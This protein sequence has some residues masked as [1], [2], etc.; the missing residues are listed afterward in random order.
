MFSYYLSPVGPYFTFMMVNMI[1]FYFYLT[2]HHTL[3]D[4]KNSHSLSHCSIGEKSRTCMAKFSAQVFT[5]LKWMCLLKCVLIWSSGCSSKLLGLWRISSLR[6][7]DWGH[8]LFLAIS[9]DLFS[10]PKVTCIPCCVV[11]FIS[12]PSRANLPPSKSISHF[13]S[14]TSTVSDL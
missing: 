10:V 3:S 4:L 8:C 14:L 13:E 5:R 11:L 12:K 6:V 1:V 7:W 9:Q 2:N